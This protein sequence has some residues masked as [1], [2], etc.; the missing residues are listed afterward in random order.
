MR[1]GSLTI[2]MQLGIEEAALSRPPE[3][4]LSIPVQ[5]GAWVRVGAA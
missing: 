5:S 1:V 3:M 4:V 2:A